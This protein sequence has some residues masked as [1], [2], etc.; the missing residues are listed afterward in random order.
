MI[1]F[2]ILLNQICF[3]GMVKEDIY[4][5]V[6]TMIKE[7]LERCKKLLKEA[8]VDIYIVPTSDFHQSEYVGEYFKGRQFLSGFTGSAGTLLISE[9]ECCLWVDGRY[10]IQARQ[11]LEGSDIKVMEMGMPGIPTI[12]EYLHQYPSS[13]LGFDGRV[14]SAKDILDFNNKKCIYDIDI[15]DT[16]WTT[17]PALS[18]EPG[19]LYD[20]KYCGETRLSKIKRI[21][22]EMKDCK[23]HILT[24]LEDIAWVFNIRGKDMKCNPMLLA[25]AIINKED[26]Y[27][28]VQDNTLCNTAM[29]T[30]KQEGIIVKEYTQIYQ[31]VQSLT[32]KILL[33]T[34]SVN[35][36]IYKNINSTCTLED[37][38]NPNQYFKAIKND[39]EIK[40]TIQAHTK[41]GVAM[42]K[43]MYWLKTNIDKQEMDELS[44]SATLEQFRQ[45]QDLFYD[46]SFDTI[47]GY[48][49]NGSLMHYKA[50]KEKYST[51]HQKG[52]LLI[53]SGGQ[54][55]DGTT[56]ITRTFALGDITTKQRQDFTIVLKAMLRLSNA[57]FL[58]GATG[59]YLDILARGVVYEYGLDYRCG[60]GHGVGHFLGVHEGPN[61]IRPTN[62]PGSQ[63]S[64]I[65]EEGM[66]TTNEPG[67]YREGEYG[68]RLE[69]ELLCIKDKENEYGQFMKFETIT[70]CPIDNDAI[71]FTMLNATELKQLNEYHQEV[72]NKVSPY[73]TIEEQ[74][75][76]K[77]FIKIES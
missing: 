73:L 4:K 58:Y 34:S 38:V 65:L 21:R 32:G 23:H 61:S 18:S 42:T 10:F 47:C 27:L 6:T 14:M 15:V 69:N 39:I 55:L 11:Q 37:R 24:S 13:T 12:K 19:F 72:Y 33:D 3:N 2:V 76:L 75:W 51:V 60:T 49:E 41:D 74:T 30:L 28:Y 52:L 70:Y 71:D 25:Y 1:I 5:G 56:D 48:Q 50:T 63:P 66:I 44:I 54:Y 8:A 26:S 67:I 40:N 62:R 9:K 43:F 36:T 31:D 46:L 35:Y 22:T 20:T 7:N 77:D 45:Q 68:I 57:Y 53:D 64:C 16:V 17:R 59:Q 29:E